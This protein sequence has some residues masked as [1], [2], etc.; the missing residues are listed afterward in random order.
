MNQMQ[1]GIIAVDQDLRVI[2]VTPVAKQ[3]LG[4]TGDVRWHAY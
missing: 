1:N 3:L 2:V 4:I